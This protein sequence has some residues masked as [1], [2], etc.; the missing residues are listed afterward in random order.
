MPDVPILGQTSA[1]LNTGDLTPEQREVLAKMAEENPPAED[2]IGTPVTTAFIVAVGL[3]GAVIATADLTEKYVPR[4][5]ATPDDI[6]GAASVVLK[7]LQSMETAQRTQQ[8]MMMMGQAMQRQAEE[9][10]L[11]ASLKI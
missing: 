2:E 5:G 3:D 9:Q 6:Y 10:R 1:P 7:D 8:A 11:R 4:R